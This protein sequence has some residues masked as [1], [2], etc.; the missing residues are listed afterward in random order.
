MGPSLCAARPDK[1][2]S[3]MGAGHDSASL[4]LRISW[5]NG[6][7]GP[8]PDVGVVGPAVHDQYRQGKQ[9]QWPACQAR[10]AS[11]AIGTMTECGPVQRALV[12]NAVVASLPACCPES[13]SFT[14]HFPRL[15]FPAG[16]LS[17]FHI[18]ALDIYPACTA[19]R[20]SVYITPAGPLM[21]G[22][23]TPP[24]MSSLVFSR[25]AYGETPLSCISSGSGVCYLT[26]AP[27]TG[28]IC[29]HW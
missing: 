12:R 20:N 26:P 15:L 9:S 5:Q 13:L 11:S 1:S 7:T 19:R 28:C 2:V 27:G 16:R 6:R 8:I 21:A 24:Y 22:M 3:E 10:E 18:C 4:R 29:S 14:M 25:T 17:L 23:L